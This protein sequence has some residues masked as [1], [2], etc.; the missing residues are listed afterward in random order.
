MSLERVQRRR[1]SRIAG[2]HQELGTGLEQVIG[3]LDRKRLKLL[4]SALSVGKAGGVAEV[5]VILGGQRDEELVQHGQAAD[6]GVE[7]GPR[8]LGRWCGHGKHGARATGGYARVVRALVV[9]AMYP[10]AEHPALGS[11]VRDQVEALRRLEGVEVEVF[12]YSGGSLIAYAKAAQRLRGR[13][14]RGRFDVVHAHFGLSAWPSLMV[15][16]PVHAVTLHGTDLAH[17]RSRA[18]TLSSLRPLDL[19]AVVSEPLRTSV[20]SWATRHPVAV[21][22]CGVSLQRFRPVPRAEACRQLGLDPERPYVLFPAAPTRPEKRFDRAQAVAGEV[23]LLTLGEVP[24][25]KVPLLINAANAVVITSEREGFGL[26]VLEALACDVPVLATDVG[27]APQ[28]LRDLPGV[29]CG[30]FDAQ[31]WRKALKPHISD[32]DPRIQGRARA[33]PFSADRLA[34]DVAEAWRRALA[35]KAR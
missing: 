11:F 35:A 8:L 16:G 24:P 17:P 19:V 32:P 31:T 9:T 33:E 13:Y 28:V 3:D 22:P 5:Q 10:S 20:P 21:L 27:I 30:P 14:E 1:A 26:A 34:A 23:A 6:S 7:H 29:Y 18:I 4:L 2:H 15:P 25:E 12:A